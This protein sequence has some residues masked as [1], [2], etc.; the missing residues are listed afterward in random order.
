MINARNATKSQLSWKY[1]V[2]M[3]FQ[4]DGRTDMQKKWGALGGPGA[5]YYYYY[6]YLYYYYYYHYY[7][8]YYYY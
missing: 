2:A 4:E 5:Y 8:Y 7:Y 6:Y 3:V 1:G